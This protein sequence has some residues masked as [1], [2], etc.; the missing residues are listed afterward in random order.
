MYRTDHWRYILLKLL[1]GICIEQ[2]I[3]DTFVL[4]L[5]CDRG[6][7]QSLWHSTVIMKLFE[8]VFEQK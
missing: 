5:F 8:H 6:I 4:A 2:I 1:G 7:E 3:G